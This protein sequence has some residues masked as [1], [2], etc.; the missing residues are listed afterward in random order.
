MCFAAREPVCGWSRDHEGGGA[1]R[2]RIA[3]GCRSVPVTAPGG[4]WSR[5]RAT[6]GVVVGV[7]RVPRDGGKPAIR[8]PFHRTVIDA[9]PG[10]AIVINRREK[11]DAPADATPRDP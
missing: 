11:M 4:I 1:G 6:G 2:R 3:N 9:S 5:H 10:R 8:R 7:V